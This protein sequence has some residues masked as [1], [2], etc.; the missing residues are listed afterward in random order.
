[1]RHLLQA[2]NLSR[3]FR[4]GGGDTLNVIKDVSLGLDSGEVVCLLGASGCGKTTLL[5]MLAGLEMPDA[6]V[7]Q[8][9]I[10]RPG[11]KL[12][13]M[14]QADGLLPWRTVCGNVSLGPELL[15]QDT[16]EAGRAAEILLREVGLEPFSGSYPHQISGGMRQ[17]A[18]LA[19]MLATQPEVLLLDEPMSNLDIVARQE[20]AAIIKKYVRDRAAAALVVTHSVEEAC[21]LADRILLITQSPAVIHEEMTGGNFMMD[22][23]LQSLRQTLEGGRA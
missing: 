9:G 5:R 12:G 2:Q 23:V 22:A 21:F 15:G 20:M 8:S 19:R 13:Y 17:R 10:K 11:E 18:L 6:G 14:I 16:K 3:S 4:Q 7:I 1:M